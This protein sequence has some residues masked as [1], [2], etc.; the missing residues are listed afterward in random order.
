M[1]SPG[2]RS[3]SPLRQPPSM[4]LRE[5]ETAAVAAHE[6]LA[7][8]GLR[9]AFERLQNHYAHLMRR[10]APGDRDGREAAYLM[11]RALDALAA[12][13][14]GVISGARILRHNYRSVIGTDEDEQK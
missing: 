8:P 5:A 3:P 13:L 11:L 6:T 9:A 2:F 14:A 1:K 10:S 4:A 7:D 12:D